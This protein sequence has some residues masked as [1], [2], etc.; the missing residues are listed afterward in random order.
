MTMEEDVAN[1]KLKRQSV[2][3]DWSLGKPGRDFWV[4][5]HSVVE[6]HQFGGYVPG[7]RITD[8][9]GACIQVM[10]NTQVCPG[11][12]KKKHVVY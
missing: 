2:F 9:S 10:V 3:S 11:Y 12:L 5:F 7:H 6:G 1:K 4:M 8:S